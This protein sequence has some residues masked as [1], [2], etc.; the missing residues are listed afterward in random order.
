[1]ESS[2]TVFCRVADTK[3]FTKAAKSLF[4]SQSAV[5]QQI[6]SLESHYGARLFV[7]SKQE[8]MLTPEGE[9]LYNYSKQI[10]KLYHLATDRICKESGVLSGSMIVGASCTIGEY[11]LP[12]IVGKFK[13]LYPKVNLFFHV[14]NNENILE[15]IRQNKFDLGF[16]GEPCKASG[17]ETDFFTQDEIVIIAA[18]NHPLT[19]KETITI[20]ELCQT[21]F[22]IRENGTGT[23]KF[24]EDFL[25]QYSLTLSD[26]NIWFEYGSFE[27]IKRFVETGMGISMLSKWAV[28]QEIDLNLLKELRIEGH[29]LVRKFLFAYRK[30]NLESPLINSFIHFCQENQLELLST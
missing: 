11:I 19:K 23:R 9:I 5:S 22:I 14:G 10:L 20:D 8:I 2:L 27:S 25:K 4:L 16:I 12:L 17:L 29:L 7:R 30:E 28:K 18:P 21:Q 13:N 6:S 24:I 15:G 26:L 1:M 3:S